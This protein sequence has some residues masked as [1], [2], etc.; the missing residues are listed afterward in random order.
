MNKNKVSVQS[1]D[2]AQAIANGSQKKG[3]S[4]EQTKLI[5]A[6]IE[7]GIALYKKQHKAKQRQADK[8]KKQLKKQS[9][10]SDI[11]EDV[12]EPQLTQPHRLLPWFLLLASWIG[13]TAYL[14]LI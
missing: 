10:T 12:I 4:K 7:K 6:G 8:H 13:F 2:D 9:S 5:A 1:H 14:T 11:D 3:Q